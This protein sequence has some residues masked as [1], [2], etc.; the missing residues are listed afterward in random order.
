MDTTEEA[1]VEARRDR[2]T[3]LPEPPSAPPSPALQAL[4]AAR[5]LDRELRDAFD[6]DELEPV[7]IDLSP[8]ALG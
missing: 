5:A 6:H 4:E 2:T 3:E 8:G 7:T 1:T